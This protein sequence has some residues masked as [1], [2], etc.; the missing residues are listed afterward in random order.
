MSS[1]FVYN[2]G[3]RFEVGD[4]CWIVIGEYQHPTGY[5]Q[6]EVIETK[7]SRDYN[8]S[9]KAKIVD[10]AVAAI[11]PSYSYIESYL[12]YVPDTCS[13]LPRSKHLDALV[14][15]IR[16]LETKIKNQDR[17][18][19]IRENAFKEALAAIGKK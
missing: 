8:T 16:K 9:L 10:P 18:Y 1:D 14:E 17:F 15:E 7:D 2:S 11:K 19:S 5:W 4:P 3:Y 13:I 6:G 12:G